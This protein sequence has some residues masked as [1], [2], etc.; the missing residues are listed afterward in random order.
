MYILFTFINTCEYRNLGD[1]DDKSININHIVF[2]TIII[3][4]CLAI[5]HIPFLVATI[6]VCFF[7]HND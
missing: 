4:F 7:P 6:V 3:S 1:E 2:N 5:Y